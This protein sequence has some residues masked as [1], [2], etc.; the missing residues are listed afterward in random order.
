MFSFRRAYGSQHRVLYLQQS[1]HRKP[2][3]D[4][5]EGN[6]YS[7]HVSPMRRRTDHVVKVAFAGRP[8]LHGPSLPESSL[9]DLPQAIQAILRKYKVDHIV[10][11]T[12]SVKK[13]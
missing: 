8:I 11:P 13:K 9:R 12:R 7:I 4:C 2:G 1:Y 6:K 10:I 3:N 5:L